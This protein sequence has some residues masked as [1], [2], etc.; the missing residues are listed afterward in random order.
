MES[1][2]SAIKK[3][4]S[5]PIS[6]A[7]VSV[8]FFFFFASQFFSFINPS[9]V[10][11]VFCIFLGFAI[12]IIYLFFSKRMLDN[13]EKSDKTF[14]FSI[15]MCDF[16]V[17]GYFFNAPS[18]ARCISVLLFMVS[19]FCIYN[20]KLMLIPVV[21]IFYS[22]IYTPSL[23]IIVLCLLLSLSLLKKKYSVLSF[24]AS[25]LL[26]GI[27]LFLYYIKSNSFDTLYFTLI[28]N[29]YHYFNTENIV[30][31]FLPVP[32]TLFFTVFWI[33]TI[34]RESKKAQR[35][36]YALP[37]IFTAV[38]LALKPFAN[39]YIG[40]FFI[41]TIFICFF[42]TQNVIGF[43]KELHLTSNYLK[44]HPL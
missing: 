18:I 4:F 21:F 9:A 14:I 1:L 35:F 2:T 27:R 19:L 15:L 44:Q 16:F 41:N 37:V 17:Y 43:K 5:E 42:K 34:A 30:K 38:F 40:P 29:E 7:C 11:N 28:S 36:A 20:N 33:K 10:N 13:F 26:A 6:T 24:T 23:S 3:Y 32:V 39:F 12:C 25:I 22:L 8:V 31:L